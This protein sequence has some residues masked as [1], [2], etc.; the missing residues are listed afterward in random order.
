MI[1]HL[2]TI[3]WANN[4][5]FNPISA[6]RRLLMDLG[7]AGLIEEIE[8]RF[9]SLATNILIFCLMLLVFV[10]SIQAVLTGLV[11]IERLVESENP[12]DQIKGAAFRL[13]IFLLSMAAIY[14]YFI[15][16]AKKVAKDAHKEVEVMF[17]ELSAER[18]KVLELVRQLEGRFDSGDGS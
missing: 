1:V 9:G 15:H 13:G 8:K 10:W 12:V 2:K 7:F 3:A 14:G 16:K 17:A 18:K 11:A 6:F 5:A 4:V